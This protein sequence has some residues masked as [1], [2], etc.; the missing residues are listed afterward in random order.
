M[1]ELILWTDDAKT[2]IDEVCK[3]INLYPVEKESMGAVKFY[4]ES[5]QMKRIV[6]VSSLMYSTDYIETIEV[7]CAVNKMISMIQPR[8]HDLIS[9]VNQYNLH[10]KFCVVINVS[11][12]P[13]I[14]LPSEFAK[15][16]A[17][18]SAEIEFDLY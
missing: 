4:G 6:D 2:S 17:W 3:S 18:L 12:K 8:I 13:I 16:M 10:A 15:V 5:K 11:E 1:V 7:E 14:I 9:A